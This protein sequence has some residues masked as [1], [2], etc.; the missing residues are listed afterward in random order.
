MMRPRTRRVLKRV[1]Y[2]A[3]PPP[4]F[5]AATIAYWR[6]QNARNAPYEPECALLSR[7]IRG[8]DL[9]VDLGVNFGQYAAR[10]ARLV[11]PQGRVV[12][13]EPVPAAFAIARRVV[14][15]PQVE[16]HGVAVSDHDG[17][18]EVTLRADDDGVPNFGLST[19]TAGAS[20]GGQTIR[21]GSCRLDT[22]FKDRTQPVAFVKCD[23]EGHELEAL[24]G[25]LE[26]IKADRPAMLVESV[27]G[28]RPALHA[29]LAPFGYTFRELDT[30]GA[31]RPVGA[32][33]GGDNVLLVPP[34][35]AA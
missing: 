10:M 4:L 22:W 32:G 26:L 1:L 25:G 13:F 33:A 24:A 8:G 27:R 5:A 6:W 28:N 17:Y 14:R 3:L 2:R 9:V 30:S 23:I 35:H 15:S 21:V 7:F 34:Q 20:V 12:G 18:V 11:G 31:L 16:I 19:V 29:L